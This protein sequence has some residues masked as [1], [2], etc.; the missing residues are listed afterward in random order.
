MTCFDLLVCGFMPKTKNFSRA[1]MK[2][3]LLL[4]IA[5]DS[6]IFTTKNNSVFVIFMFEILKNR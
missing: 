5:K 1:R 6:H 3:L 4:C 2:L